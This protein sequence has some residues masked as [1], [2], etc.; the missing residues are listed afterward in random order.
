MPENRGMYILSAEACI[1]KINGLWNLDDDKH[2]SA[3]SHCDGVRGAAMCRGGAGQTDP[4]SPSWLVAQVLSVGQQ[5]Q[6]GLQHPCELRP[7][8]PSEP[9]QEM[10]LGPH[11]APGVSWW[12]FVCRRHS[13]NRQGPHQ[14]RKSQLEVHGET[15]WHRSGNN[16]WGDAC[17]Q[18]CEIV[19]ISCLQEWSRWYSHQV[20]DFRGVQCGLSKSKAKHSREDNP[21][22]LLWQQPAHHSSLA[23]NTHFN[24][25][26]PAIGHKITSTPSR[27]LSQA[28]QARGSRHWPMWWEIP[29]L[30]LSAGTPA[31][32]QEKSARGNAWLSLNEEW[33]YERSTLF[34]ENSQR[35]R[36]AAWPKLIISCRWFTCF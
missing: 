19:H 11:N 12:W 1:R 35:G 5:R 17:E 29:A 25:C 24:P 2:G 26:A 16:R 27:L 36:K 28:V 8:C 18:S 9:L 6:L 3:F 21:P 33:T 15:P 4:I 32:N 14:H 20:L 30:P 23:H 22:L 34:I 31:A 13:S 7:A 10:V